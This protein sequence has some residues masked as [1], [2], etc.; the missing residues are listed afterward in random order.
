[1]ILVVGF[2]RET[3]IATFKKRLGHMLQKLSP[4]A[5][6]FLCIIFWLAIAIGTY[7][8]GITHKNDTSLYRP[9]YLLAASWQNIQSRPLIGSGLGTFTAVSEPA[10]PRGEVVRFNQPVHHGP[11]LLLSELG[12]AGSALLLAMALF[13]SK[14]FF[15]HTWRPIT[16]LLLTLTPLLVWDHYLISLQSGWLVVMLGVVFTQ[17]TE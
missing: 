15:S 3:H 14:H 7:S 16:L 4:V 1:M 13:A 11:I 6:A 9:A 12:L 10:L 8:F 5:V 17:T 2:S